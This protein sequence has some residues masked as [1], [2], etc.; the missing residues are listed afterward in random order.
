MKGRLVLVTLLAFAGDLAAQGAAGPDSGDFSPETR[1][2]N[3]PMS[4]ADAVA[5]TVSRHPQ[6][7]QAFAHLARGRADVDAARSVW[8]PTLTYRGNLGPD[9]T[10]SSREWEVNDAPTG[11]GVA[12]EQLIWDFGRSRGQIDA[13]SEVERQRE[14]ELAATADRLAEEA[15]LAFLDVKR[16]E[17]LQAAAAGHIESL[18]RLRELIRLRSDAGLSDKSD[19]LLAGVRVESAR[20]EAVQIRTSQ[21]SAELAL[22]NLT[23]ITP[24]RHLDPAP[25]IDTFTTRRGEPRLDTLPLV[26]AAEAAERAAASRIEQFRAE[27]YPRLGLQVGY[28]RNHYSG[29]DATVMPQNS[30]TALVTVTGDLYRGGTRHALRGAIEDR[31]AARAVRE[32]VALDLR[33]RILA[34]REQIESGEARIGAYRS[35]EEH[36]IRTSRIFLEEYKLGKRSLADL[37][38]AELEIYRAASARIAAEYDVMRARIQHEAAYGSLRQSLG[39]ATRLIEEGGGE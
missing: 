27:R 7:A 23:G 6:I 28:N 15:A 3:A 20:G 37:L 10:S 13:A 1:A 38:S 21:I 11:V 17:L 4:I 24:A 25:I 34:A 9:K 19:L 14:L 26:A 22:A 36:A 31:R 12:L 30:L 5:V 35:Q 39:I 16:Y 18:E 8:Y 32:S 33:G 29:F 2:S